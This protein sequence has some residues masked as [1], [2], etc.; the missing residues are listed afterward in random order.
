MKKE[1]C[2]ILFIADK[3]QIEEV[4]SK[5]SEEEKFESLSLYIDH[6]I[7]FDFHGLL[8]ILY[9]VDVSEEKVKR[10]LI[11]HSKTQTP[12]KTIAQLLIERASEKIKLREKY[13]KK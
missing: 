8:H 12:G 3:L 2:P 11:L 10:A 4:N 9:R 1:N 7:K 5:Q 6:L 13:S